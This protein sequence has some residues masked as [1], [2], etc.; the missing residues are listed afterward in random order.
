MSRIIPTRLPIILMAAFLLLGIQT[1][2]SFAHARYERSEPTDQGMVEG[3]PFVLKAWFN[4]ELMSASTIKVVDAA[5]AQVD[6]ADGR[7]DLDDVDRKLM[8]VSLPELPVGVYTVA[9]ASL[10][11]EDGDWA[12]GTFTFGIG[13][14]PPTANDQLP[15]AG[16]SP[17]VQPSY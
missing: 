15:S 11:A 9:W 4:Q 3:T 10:S 8:V 14:A 16:T 13:M 1:A 7:V 17:D 12:D 5:G 6:L 2:P